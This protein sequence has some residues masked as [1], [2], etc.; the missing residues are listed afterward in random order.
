VVVL[1]FLR[2]SGR[3]QNGCR[4]KSEASNH[5][6]QREGCA[7][8]DRCAKPTSEGIR[9]QP[10]CVAERELRGEQRRAVAGMR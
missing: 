7:K 3:P 1:D 4:C 6:Q 5:D 9:Q 2:I 10:A 8:P